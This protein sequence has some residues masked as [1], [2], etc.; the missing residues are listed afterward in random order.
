VPDA[1][2]VLAV[3]AGNP[4]VVTPDNF[5]LSLWPTV[6]DA[7]EYVTEPGIPSD[8]WAVALIE[9]LMKRRTRTG[10]RARPKRLTLADEPLQ[11]TYHRKRKPFGQLAPATRRRYIRAGRE[12]GW[13][14]EQTR[15]YY[16]NGRTIPGVLK[17]DEQA[18]FHEPGAWQ[19]YITRNQTRLASKYGAETAQGLLS[20]A[21]FQKIQW[22]ANPNRTPS[23]DIALYI[24][25][26]ARK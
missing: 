22:A 3:V 17:P 9:G 8:Y 12:H 6:E 4:A 16:K 20:A 18:L 1:P 23:A 13:T 19:Q 14:D 26:G 2:R 10:K 11:R 21:A 25:P 15:A 24:A 7:V 5:R